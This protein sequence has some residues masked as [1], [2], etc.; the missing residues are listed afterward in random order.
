MNNKLITVLA[1]H[2]G[3]AAAPAQPAITN[4]PQSL[5]VVAGTNAVFTVGATGAPPLSYQWRSHASNPSYTNIP[6][7]TEATLV[8]TNVQ[9]TSRRFAVVVTDAGGLSATSSPLAQLTVVF[10]P[11]ITRQPASQLAELGYPSAISVTATG[12]PPLSY[13]WLFNGQTIAGETRTNL[14]WTSVQLS[15]AGAYSVL[16]TNSYGSTNSQVATLTVVPPIFT[17]I[18]NGVIVTEIGTGISPA[19]GDYDKDGFIDL[20]L[21]SGYDPSNNSSQKLILYHNNRDGTFSKVTNTVITSIAQDWRGCSWADYDNDGNLDLVAVANEAN[22]FAGSNYLFHNNGNGSFTA[23]T[24]TNTS[25]VFTLM[26]IHSEGPVWADYNRDGFV[27]LFLAKYGMDWFYRNNGDGTFTQLTNA[28]VGLI[29]DSQDSYNA[30]W[31]DYDNDGWPD[32]FVSVKD[33]NGLNQTNFF[34]HN[35]GNGTFARVFSGSI[36]TD[37][38]YSIACIWGDYDNDGHPDLFVTSGLN[39]NGTN[40]LY[41][42]NGNGSF[43][44]MSSQEVG[45]LVSDV[46][47]FT[48]ATWGDYDNDGF[49]DL[50]VAT[51]TGQPNPIHSNFLYHN[52]GDGTFTRIM[53]GS[54]VNEVGFSYGCAW[55][56]Y[57]NDGFLDLFVARG[58]DVAAATNRLYRNNGNSKGWIKLKLVGTVSNRVAIGA[59]VRIKAVIHGQS[60]WQ[61]REVNTG[62][63]YCANQLDPHFGLGDATNIDLV[64]IEWPSGIV[65]ELHDVTPRQFLTIT[66]PSQLVVSHDAANPQFSI[67]GW[68]G[69]RYDI[70]ASTNLF[71]WVTVSTLTVTN[72]RGTAPIVD[73]NALDAGRRFYRAVLR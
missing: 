5:T 37:N 43:T 55:G 44:R 13:Q 59:K 27:D 46:S 3:L 26:A 72:Q 73:T 12:T 60:V 19:W 36:G 53:S 34:Y 54:V 9:P 38:D 21:T 30:M 18:T 28:L 1:I 10:P 6:W 25:G 70:D 14:T 56:D 7:G 69:M 17:K 58:A 66:E 32:L 48:Q 49:L 41:H 20:C 68:R 62:D 31:A 64:R 15:N 51:D 57:D 65:Q 4:Q 2:L 8:L 42:N 33:P 16:I 40:A 22:G 24:A 45:S 29:A 39:R 47:W 23:M 52:N 11:S 35:Q 67:R 71:D 63:G 61:L 50:F